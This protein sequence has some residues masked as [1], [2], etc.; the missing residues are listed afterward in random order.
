MTISSKELKNI[1]KLCKKEG[2]SRI[3]TSDLE[4]EFKETIK[5]PM[6][7]V[8]KVKDNPVKREEI[9]KEAIGQAEIDIKE[10]YVENLI[11]EDPSEYE[12]LMIQGE[13][14]AQTQDRGPEQNLQ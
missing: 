8:G 3:K 14:D 4:I 9:E 11:L 13:F 6:K 1:L 10:N 7:S 5:N 12:S 2:V